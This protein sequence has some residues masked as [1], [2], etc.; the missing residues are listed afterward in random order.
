MAP[1]IVTQNGRLRM[2]TGSPGGSRIITTVLETLLDTL[3]YG[4]SVA[5]A[6]DAPRTH[7]QWLPDEVQ[8]EPRLFRRTLQ[9]RCARWATRCMRY[10]NGGPRRP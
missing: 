3:T 2:V 4:M 7:M 8:Y 6:V 9:A 1:T 5:A 10:R